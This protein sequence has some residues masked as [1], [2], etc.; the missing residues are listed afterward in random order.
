METL[1]PTCSLA[2][3]GRGSADT[4][5]VTSSFVLVRAFA[6]PPPDAKLPLRW[7]K[8]ADSTAD[9]YAAE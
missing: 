6:M 1:P 2:Q 3:A 5:C 9:T 8:A 4:M 7:A